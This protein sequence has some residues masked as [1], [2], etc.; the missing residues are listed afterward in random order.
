MPMPEA[1]WFLIE[2]V[3]EYLE[4]SGPVHVEDL[5]ENL[6]VSETAVALALTWLERHHYVEPVSE[7]GFAS[8]SDRD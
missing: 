3:M 2:M 8:K 4:D 5:A 6:G 1:P 7:D